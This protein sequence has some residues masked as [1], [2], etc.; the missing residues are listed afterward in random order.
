MLGMTPNGQLELIKQCPQLRRLS[1]DLFGSCRTFPI[2]EFA[3]AVAK[4]TW[5]ELEHLQLMRSRASDVLLSLIVRGMQ[6]VV[7]LSITHAAFADQ[8]MATLRPHFHW[9]RQL[10]VTRNFFDT[11]EFMAEILKSCPKLESLKTDGISAEY[12]LDDQPWAC[13]RSLKVL[14]VCFWIAPTSFDHH[15]QYKQVFRRLLKLE[16]LERLDM[17]NLESPES[18]S[19]V[20]LQ[21]GAGL[22][23]LS[24]LKRLK[25]L[26]FYPQPR[27]QHNCRW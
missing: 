19:T 12:L 3:Q 8:A 5:P 21:L 27:Y 24:T 18:V 2:H 22:E 20:E 6:R 13:E 23:Q 25:E 7:S 11:S 9:L 17:S 1:W 10:N 14:D 4:T 16:N 15:R 26:V